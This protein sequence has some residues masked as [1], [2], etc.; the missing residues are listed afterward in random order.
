MN[1]V[2]VT[3]PI[4]E[5]LKRETSKEAMDSLEL[6]EKGGIRSIYVQVEMKKVCIETD[7]TDKDLLKYLIRLVYNWFFRIG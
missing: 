1:V 5:R 2:N 6:I 3:Q 7:V 4:K